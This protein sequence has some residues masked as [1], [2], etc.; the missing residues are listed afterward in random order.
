MFLDE[1]FFENIINLPGKFLQKLL[2]L[3]VNEFNIFKFIIVLM[4]IFIFIFPFMYG[5]PALNV[6]E[7]YNLPEFFDNHI[8]IIY[9]I[10]FIIL[11]IILINIIRCNFKQYQNIIYNILWIVFYEYNENIQ[12]LFLF[13]VFMFFIYHN[14]EMFIIM[15]IIH[16]IIDFLN[17]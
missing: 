8:I 2:S 7:I 17:C 13:L 16:C 12:I 4:C 14:L 3:N 6:G 5:A 1:A 15:C 11:L 9:M 10:I